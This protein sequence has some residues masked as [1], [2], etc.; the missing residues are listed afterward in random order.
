[1]NNKIAF[2]LSTIL[3]LSSLSAQAQTKTATNTTKATAS[4]AS[5]CV[6]GTNDVVFGVYNPVAT[7]DTQ[8]TQ[9]V[10]IRC[11]KGTPWNFYE[12]AL[13]YAYAGATNSTGYASA[14]IY[15]GNKLY[16]QVQMSDGVWDNDVDMSGRPNNGHFLGTGTGQTQT[17]SINYRIIKNQYVPPGNYKDTATVYVDF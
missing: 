14:M 7:S 6:I 1:M 4:L 2:I 16:Y 9:T 3:G 10:S 8:T 11:T 12:Y 15:N 13:Y 17:L 5:S